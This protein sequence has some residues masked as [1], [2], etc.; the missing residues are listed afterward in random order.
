[1]DSVDDW[2]L[3]HI[4]FEPVRVNKT[5]VIIILT[6]KKNIYIYTSI[7]FLNPISESEVK[8]VVGGDERT[9]SDSKNISSNTFRFKSV[10][11]HYVMTYE[12]PGS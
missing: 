7:I 1:M 4:Y 11:K 12:V 8:V 9:L 10:R 3:T 5:L 6:P 2:E